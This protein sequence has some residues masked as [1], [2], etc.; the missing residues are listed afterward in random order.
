MEQQG[1]VGGINKVS[2]TMGNTAALEF[3]TQISQWEI[4]EKIEKFPK[5]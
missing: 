3:L 1:E 4:I 5:K 2:G